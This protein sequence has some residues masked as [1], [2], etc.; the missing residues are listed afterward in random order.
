MLSSLTQISL[1]LLAAAFLSAAPALAAEPSAEKAPAPAQTVSAGYSGNVKTR[2]FHA[3]GCRYFQCKSCTVH[4]SSAEEARSGGYK[5][6]KR[7]IK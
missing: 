2:V 6:C 5:P 3:S 4:F 1:C 7:C